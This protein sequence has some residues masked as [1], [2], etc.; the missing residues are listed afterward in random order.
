LDPSSLELPVLLDALVLGERWEMEEFIE[1][2]QD[3]IIQD[4][5]HPGTL[6]QGK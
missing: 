2:V 1:E 4:W 3:C 6:I 5:L